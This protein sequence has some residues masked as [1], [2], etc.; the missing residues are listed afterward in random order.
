MY[1]I[2][3][4]F[5]GEPDNSLLLEKTVEL[6]LH[7]ESLRIEA[8]VLGEQGPLGG[9]ESSGL[10]SETGQVPHDESKLGWKVNCHPALLLG[11]GKSKQ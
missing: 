4:K 6:A 1:T 8:E 11:T 7:L 5:N 2:L 9:E 10:E 3:K